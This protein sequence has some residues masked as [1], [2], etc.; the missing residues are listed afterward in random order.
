M[1]F[2]L[3]VVGATWNG[4]LMPPL[5]WLNLALIAGLAL[6]WLVARRRAGWTWHRNPLDGPLLLWVFAF[7]LAL[8]ANLESWRRIMM[9]LWYMGLYVGVW[10][11]LADAL[12]NRAIRRETLIDGLLLGGLAVVAF[13]Y[14]QVWLEGLRFTGSVIGSV[15]GNPNSLGAYLIVLLGFASGR[16]LGADNRLTRIVLGGYLL[17]IATL[18]LLTFS[19]GAWI[20]GAM[21]FATLAGLIMVARH[22]SP[23]RAPYAWWRARSASLRAGLLSVALALF[24]AG[25]AFAVLVA[26]PI[27]SEPGRDP[28]L[29]FSLWRGAT[30]MFSEQPLTGHG[31]FTFGQQLPR[32]QSQPPRQPHSHA[33]NGPLHIAAELGLPGLLALLASVGALLAAMRRNWRAV[34]QRQRMLLVGAL[35]SSMG[36]GFHH[37]VDL[38]AM[39]PLIAL[40]GLLALSVATTPLEPTPARASWRQ[41]TSPGMVALLLAGLVASGVWSASVYSSYDDAIRYVLADESSQRDYHAGAERMQA[42]VDA[43]PSLALYRSQQGYL[44]GLAALEY[45]D[46]SALPLAIRAYERLTELEP[47]YAVGW[48]NLGAVYWAA[49]QQSAALTAFEAAALAAPDSHALWFNLGLHAEQ[50]GD[51][52]LAIRAYEYALHASTQ[53]WPDWRVTP[54]RQEIAAGLP[55]DPV[56][57]LILALTDEAPLSP[58]EAD[59]LWQA[60]ELNTRQGRGSALWLL[61]EIRA[62]IPGDYAAQVTRVERQL[63]QSGRHQQ[64]WV[65]LVRAEYARHIGDENLAAAELARARETLIIDITDQD[66]IFGT[67]IA[68]FQFLRYTLPRQFLPTVFYPV[69]SDG[70]LLHLLAEES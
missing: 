66:F 49:G 25:M 70:V 22:E 53:L 30:Q 37:L 2:Y 24:A 9:G 8:L 5:K 57:E 32:I 13:G 43:D 35:A 1:M 21:A 11:V 7:G 31:L 64:G 14:V 45:G 36:F 69:V 47:G 44:Y 65:H 52:S 20:G 46:D 16:W 17:L 29:R 27:F 62:G 33:H 51:E 58:A 6:L 12:A 42:A 34:P 61:L 19:R 39:M 15:I 28:G 3:S 48:A 41:Q 50:F 4:V 38:P 68:H 60:S 63:A 55:L 10:F 23:W 18:L 67:N 59:R 54:L 40:V 26:W 56:S